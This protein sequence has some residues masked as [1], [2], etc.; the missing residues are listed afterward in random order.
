M[1]ALEIGDVAIRQI[2]ETEHLLMAPTTLFPAAAPAALTEGL[3]FADD[4]DV[5]CASANLVIGVSGYLVRAGGTTILV[6]TGAAGPATA[7]RFMAGLAAAGCEP[8]RPRPPSD[9][10][11]TD[12]RIRKASRSSEELELAA[13]AEA[14]LRP[15]N[16]ASAPR[17]RRAHDH[18][19][20][21]GDV[22]PEHPMGSRWNPW[23]SKA[24]MGQPGLSLRSRS[25][26]AKHQ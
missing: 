13:P 3:S 24:R 2:V 10:A 23:Q 17:E 12:P 6:D 8:A 11:A 18:G 15:E 16:G 5:D 1:T 9:R 7:G 26:H 25:A 21:H 19:D 22:C 20:S 4:C 14:A